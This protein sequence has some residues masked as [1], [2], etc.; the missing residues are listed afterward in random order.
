MQ[1]DCSEVSVAQL[2]RKR[3]VTPCAFDETILVEYDSC[4]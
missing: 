3:L 4:T 1:I 2:V